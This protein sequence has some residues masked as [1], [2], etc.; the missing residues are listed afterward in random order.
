MTLRIIGDI[1]KYLY[2]YISISN[3]ISFIN[4]IPQSLAIYLV[5]CDKKVTKTDFDQF[6]NHKVV[7]F[8]FVHTLINLTNFEVKMFLIAYISP[9]SLK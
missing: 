9:R 6:L 4:I 3:L 7:S 1:L 8:K 5:V 2:A